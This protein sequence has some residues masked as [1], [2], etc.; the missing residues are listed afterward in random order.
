MVKNQFL[1]GSEWRK[2]DLRAHT[3]LDKAW[4]DNEDLST[5]QNKKD[6]AKRYI[7]FAKHKD[8]LQ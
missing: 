1:R 5:G 7:A 4:K 2:L 6:F 8:Y 3:P